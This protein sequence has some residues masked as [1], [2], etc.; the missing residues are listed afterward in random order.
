MKK[1]SKIIDGIM[2]IKKQNQ[3]IVIKDDRQYLNPNEELLFSDGWVEYIAPTPSEPTEKELLEKAR[4][5]KLQE[6]KDSI[7][8]MYEAMGEFQSADDWDVDVSDDEW[9]YYADKVIEQLKQDL[10]HQKMR[11]RGIIV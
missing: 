8:E 3:I 2:T 10:S 11:K 7:F 6:L 1:Y 9:Y 5:R 4:S